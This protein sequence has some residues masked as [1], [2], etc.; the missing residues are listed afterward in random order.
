MS[1]PDPAQLTTFLKAKARE[2]GFAAVG[3]SKA[4]FLEEEAPR[5]EAW[6]KAG[7][8]GKMSYMERNFDKRLDPR[9]LVEGAKSVVSLAVHYQVSEDLIPRNNYRIARFGLGKDYHFVIREKLEQLVQALEPLSGP[10][11]YRVF[12]DSAPVMERAWAKRSGLGWTGKNANLIIPRWGSWFLLAELIS[13]LELTYDRAFE[14][15]YCG[16]CTNCIDAC[17]TGAIIA[18][19][20][21]EARKCI[22]CYTTEFKG[23]LP[24]ELKDSISPWIFGCDICQ[25]VC[26]WNNFKLS[27]A[28]HWLEPNPILAK[29][30]KDEWD[31]LNK[32]S[33][34][35]LFK[36][37]GINRI[38]YTRLMRNISLVK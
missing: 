38:G 11:Q 5:L 23:E 25:E 22:S 33:F 26:P 17:P 24:S 14:K 9:L 6:L 12:T 29:M 18:P 31:M 27:P 13:D 32:Q 36:N 15:D 4:D 28:Q 21:I 34:D 37:A 3:I 30:P 2:L 35:R 7:Y 20:V 16:T 1:R 10:L 8:Q 19:K